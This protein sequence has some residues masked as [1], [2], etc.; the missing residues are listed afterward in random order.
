MS[1]ARYIRPGEQL[2]RSRWQS[3][4][5]APWIRKIH[6]RSVVGSLG[7]LPEQAMK[8]TSYTLRLPARKMRAGY[9][10]ARLLAEQPHLPWS[11]GWQLRGVFEMTPYERRFVQRLYATRSNYWLF[12]CHQRVRCGDFVLLDMSSAVP[13]RRTPQVLELKQ[14]ACFKTERGPVGVQTQNAH[15]AIDEL[16]TAG[17]LS[18]DSAYCCIEAS[19]ENVLGSLRSA[20]GRAPSPVRANEEFGPAAVAS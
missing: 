12:R 8:R 3:R 11:I 17:L 1:C 5:R 13:W 7:G 14:R 19:A 6:H 10:I 2:I 16:V 15:L 9:S 20:V 18:P 4:Q